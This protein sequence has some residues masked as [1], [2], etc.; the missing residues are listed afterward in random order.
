MRKLIGTAIAVCLLLAGCGGGAKQD[1]GFTVLPVSAADQS[2]VDKL[3][4]LPMTESGIAVVSGVLHAAGVGVYPDGTAG[5]VTEPVRLMNWQIQNLAIEAANGGGASGSAL[6]AISKLPEGAP[7]V[8]YLLAA[9]VTKHDSAAAGFAR[10][11]LGEQDW[12]HAEDIIFPK[13]VLTLFIADGIGYRPTGL[14]KAAAIQN[15]DGPCTAVAD[16]ISNGINAVASA[17]KVDTSG[18]GFLGFLGTVWN[19]AV[20]LAAGVVKGILKAFKDFAFGPVIDAFA[21]LGTIQQVTAYLVQWRADLVL[22]PEDTRFGIGSEVITGRAEVRVTDNQLP[23]PPVIRDCS[24]HFGTDLSKIGS[25]ED[26]PVRWKAESFGRADLATQTKVDAKVTSQR[27]ATLYYRT[28]QESEAQVKGPQKNGFYKI[29][30]EV[31]RYDINEARRLIERITDGALPAPA[32]AVVKALIRQVV[33]AAEERFN[34]ITAVTV[35]P[36]NVRIIY[37][38][39]PPTPTPTAETAG[40]PPVNGPRKLPEGCPGIA[41]VS[42]VT[43]VNFDTGER[44]RLPGIPPDMISCGYTSESDRVSLEFGIGN[45]PADADAKHLA[46]GFQRISIPGADHAWYRA[47][48]GKIKQEFVYAV[49]GDRFVGGGA[50][51]VYER[52]DIVVKLATDLIARPDLDIVIG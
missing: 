9:W 24:K 35:R 31:Q 3:R 4:T 2:K 13:V 10:A 17:L 23:V 22:L 46:D 34:E 42:K 39:D 6:T 29:S 5:P 37:H 15:L 21:I 20:D 27:T 26:A 43:G 44:L 49:I 12:R 48:D 52:L 7:P 47:D 51:F 19:V 41:R 25:A 18:G 30:A 32:A 11:L 1:P 33:G 38:G 14:S 50:A 45:W 36:K 16:F 8:G 28:G 40:K